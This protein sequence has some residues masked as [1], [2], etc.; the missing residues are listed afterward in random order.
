M[1]KL[2]FFSSLVDEIYIYG[3]VGMKIIQEN[4]SYKI[5]KGKI[6]SFIF[7]RRFFK[8]KSLINKKPV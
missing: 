2:Y 6:K 5:V 1:R 7:H 4:S 3:K 8:T